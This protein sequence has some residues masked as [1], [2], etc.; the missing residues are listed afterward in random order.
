MATHASSDLGRRL[1]RLAGR[2]RWVTP[3]RLANIG[4]A[5]LEMKLRR[6]TLLS[7][8]YQLCIDV[9]NKC[10]LGC[11]YCPT[12]RKEPTERGKGNIPYELFCEIVDELAPTVTSLELYNWGEP[13]F[14]PDLPRLIEYAAR[15]RMVTSISTNLSFKLDAD[16]VKDVIS[17][18]LTYLTGAIDG[19]EQKAYELY[20]R[21]GR[22]DFAV[23]NLRQFATVRRAMGREFPRLCWQFLVFRHNEHQ[24]AAARELS[25]EIG[26][27]HFSVAGGLYDDPT[28]APQESYHLDYLEVHANR[29]TW[30]WNKAVFHWDGGLASCCMGY[31]KHEDFASWKQG[32]FGALWNNEKFVAARRIWTEPESPLPAGHYCVDCDKVRLYRGLP[33]K[34]QMKEATRLSVAGNG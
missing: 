16:T 4:L 19:A 3:R 31:A 17:A 13:F 33:L 26:V 6:T 29:C 30:L 9:T 8:P 14:N 22:F 10:N 20:R 32:G 18:G 11:P 27:D 25:Q 2:F 23:E 28:W 5:N 12:G 1:R 15:K 24:I 7:R 34:S 21:N